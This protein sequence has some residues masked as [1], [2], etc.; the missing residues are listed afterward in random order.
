MCPNANFTGQDHIPDMDDSKAELISAD[1]R[2]T[3]HTEFKC[4]LFL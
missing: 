4:C 1:K 2:E 3:S